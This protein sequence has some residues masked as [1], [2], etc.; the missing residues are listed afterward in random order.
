MKFPSKLITA[1][2]LSLFTSVVIAQSDSEPTNDLPNP[3]HI[4][5]GHLKMPAGR[6]WSSVSAIDIDPDGKSVWVEERC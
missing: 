5:T 1:I 6:D 4:V 3:Y 2:C